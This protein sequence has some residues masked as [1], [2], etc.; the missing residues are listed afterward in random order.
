MVCQGRGRP[1]PDLSTDA[2]V[3]I[4]VNAANRAGVEFY[5]SVSAPFLI[6]L[7]ATTTTPLLPCDEGCRPTGTLSRSREPGARNSRSP[8]SRTLEA[9]VK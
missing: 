1:P 5:R 6:D 2:K 7:M 3:G 4:F 8:K 9:G